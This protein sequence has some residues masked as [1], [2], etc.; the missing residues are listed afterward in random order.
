MGTITHKSL[1]PCA[2]RLL[3]AV[4]RAI[5]MPLA[6][7]AQ[8]FVTDVMLVGAETQSQNAGQRLNKMQKGINIVGG[9]KIIK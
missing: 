7:L 3:L 6:S 4:V 8:E 2:A 1:M 5:G 9:R